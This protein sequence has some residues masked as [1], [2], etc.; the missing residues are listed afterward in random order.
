MARLRAHKILFAAFA[1]LAVPGNPGAER[2]ATARKDAETRFSLVDW[3]EAPGGNLPPVAPEALSVQ[4]GNEVLPTMVARRV[5][6]ERPIYPTLVGLG[7]LD[8]SGADAALLS[9]LE[10]ASRGFVARSLDASLFT[11]ENGAFS[12]AVISLQMSRVGPVMGSRFGQPR[13]VEPSV[14]EVPFL[15]ELS[16]GRRFFLTLYAAKDGT[17]WRVD[18]IAVDPESY[19]DAIIAN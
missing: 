9:L 15:L 13:F 12:L 2:A 7:S 4:G 11:K 1:L 10:S 3:V 6:G 14:A 8:Y 17:A 18:Q 16:S 5:P 19:A